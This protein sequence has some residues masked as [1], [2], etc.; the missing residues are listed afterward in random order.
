VG[1]RPW[2]YFPHDIR[3]E[4]GEGS[5]P[6]P[7]GFVQPHGVVATLVGGYLL[8]QVFGVSGAGPSVIGMHAFGELPRIWPASGASQLW[9]LPYRIDDTT[10]PAVANR[11]IG[12][13]A[14]P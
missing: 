11:L 9:P 13:T 14:I 5:G 12:T 6:P 10:L 8:L 4:L 1:E 2:W 7:P 3:I